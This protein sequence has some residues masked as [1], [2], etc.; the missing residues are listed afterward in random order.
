[1]TAAIRACWD[2]YADEVG[3][4]AGEA[5]QLLCRA[6]GYAGAR[7]VQTAFEASQYLQQLTSGAALHLQ[8][9]FNVMGSPQDAATRLLRIPLRSGAP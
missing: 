5:D 2:G 8:L 4:T 7:L 3:I 1:M 6:V 9:A